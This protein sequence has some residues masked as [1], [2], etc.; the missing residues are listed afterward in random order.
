MKKKTLVIETNRY[1]MQCSTATGT[2]SKLPWTDAT[3]KETYAF[4]AI[5]IAA[6]IYNIPEFR[7]YGSAAPILN[8]AWFHDR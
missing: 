4:L 5:V 1:H 8:V 2:A 7:D 3:T 6:D